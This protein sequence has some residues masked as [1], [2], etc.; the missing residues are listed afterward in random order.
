MAGFMLLN[1]LISKP[2]L[3][4]ADV[5]QE[6]IRPLCAT[7]QPTPLNYSPSSP[8][9]EEGQG[10]VVD[11]ALAL[12]ELGGLTSTSPLGLHPG[13]A[14]PSSVQRAEGLILESP[15]CPLPTQ[16]Q[17]RQMTRP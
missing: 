9:N 13:W 11:E 3:V 12:Q 8:H 14:Y 17:A 2:I 7:C 5:A 16:P 10:L 1:N 4:Q 6:L 15:I